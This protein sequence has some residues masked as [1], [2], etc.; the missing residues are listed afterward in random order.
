VS[1]ALARR[2]LD[3]GL[4]A[5]A[6]D[7][8]DEARRVALMGYVALLS[9]WNRTYNLTGVRSP[10]EMVRRHVLDSLV[11]LPYVHGRRMLD[12]G[13]GAGVPG[14]VLALARPELECVLLDRSA[15]KV[16]FCRQAAAELAAANV[17]VVQMRVQD[18]ACER[19]FDSVVARAFAALSELVEH[20]RRLCAPHGRLLAMKGRCPQ[21]ELEALGALRERARVVAL[22]VPGLDAQRHLVILPCG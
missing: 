13:T 8:I 20:A 4:T 18:Y 3:E 19:L 21:A 1:M 5:A 6:L 2:A 9:R 14:L 7:D 11:L 10:V 12:V 15:K 22:R 16:R 17:D